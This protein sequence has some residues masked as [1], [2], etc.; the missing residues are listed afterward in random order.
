MVVSVVVLLSVPVVSVVL[1]QE[2]L[3]LVVSEVID[4]EETLDCV[5]V[6]DDTVKVVVEVCVKPVELFVVMLMVVYVILPV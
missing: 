6:S 4:A 2:V 3:V 5:E 1:V